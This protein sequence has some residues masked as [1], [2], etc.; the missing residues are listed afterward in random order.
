MANYC[1]K[2]VKTAAQLI[3]HELEQGREVRIP[4]FGR[5]YLSRE[6]IC[7]A[8]PTEA[9]EGPA[10]THLQNQVRFRPWKGLKDRA[11]KR[12]PV[13]KVQQ[14]DGRQLLCY[15]PDGKGHEGEH[16]RWDGKPY[17]H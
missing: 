9:I 14:P 5:F 10:V 13:C 1:P 3:A 17:K 12:K 11:A 2:I 16:V 7:N 4:G 6:A 15:H 8:H